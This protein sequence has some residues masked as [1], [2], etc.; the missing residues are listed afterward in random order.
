MTTAWWCE[1]SPAFNDTSPLDWCCFANQTCAEYI[2]GQVGGA[3]EITTRTEYP[4][5]YN[6]YANATLATDLWNRSPTNGT[7]SNNGVGG[8]RGCVLNAANTPSGKGGTT[9]DGDSSSNSGSSAGYREI[10]VMDPGAILAFVGIA[11]VIK[12]VL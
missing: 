11:W 5:M 2:C 4:T 6:C 12:R 8:G 7:C 3:I 9:S 1:N 10:G